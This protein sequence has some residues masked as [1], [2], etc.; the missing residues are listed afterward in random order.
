MHEDMLSSSPPASRHGAPA[1][2]A[3]VSSPCAATA[4]LAVPHGVW[5]LPPRKKKIGPSLFQN[6]G[7]E[8]TSSR[9]LSPPSPR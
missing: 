9:A 7:P 4:H 1:G 3:C 2:S 8:P 6:H 5:A